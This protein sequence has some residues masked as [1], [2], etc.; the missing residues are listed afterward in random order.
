MGGATGCQCATCAHQPETVRRIGR[1]RRRCAG[2]IVDLHTASHVDMPVKLLPPG[3][4]RSSVPDD[5]EPQTLPPVTRL[6]TELRT[7]CAVCVFMLLLS[8]A[9]STAKALWA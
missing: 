4:A 3:P 8:G 1:T 9:W 5:G 6:G 7:M 2:Y